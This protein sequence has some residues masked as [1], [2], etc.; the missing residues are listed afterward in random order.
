MRWASTLSREP[1]AAKAF[2]DA[3]HGIERR[4]DGREPD[5]VLAFVSP[6]HA[7]ACEH[8]LALAARRFPRALV[9]GCTAG[10]VIGGARE[11]EEGPAFSLTAAALPGATLSAFR[12]EPG[13]HAGGDAS[14]WRARIG[15]PPKASPRLLLLS[16]PFTMDPGALV[17][18]LDRAYPGGAEVRRARERRRRARREP[19]VRR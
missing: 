1:H 6:E 8:V 7:E 14:E 2:G 4:L 16:D 15:C 18:G 19:P 9:A 3:A 13:R 17:D 5:L 11:A 12:V 10:G